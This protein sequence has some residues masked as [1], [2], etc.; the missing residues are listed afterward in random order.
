MNISKQQMQTIISNAPKGVDTDKIQAMYISKGYNIEGVDTRQAQ[1]YISTKYPELMKTE[2]LVAPQ[3]SLRDKVQE[4]TGDVTWVIDDIR[5]SSTK[6]S[7]NIDAAQ[8]RFNTGE[9]GLASTV[10]QT[11]GQ[12]AGAGADAI[13]AAFKGATN[14]AFSDKT[15]KDITDVIGKFGAKVMANPQV[16]G[17]IN[18]YNELTPEQQANVDAVGGIVSLVGEFIGGGVGSKAAKATTKG[19]KQA[20][21]EIVGAVGDA[22][23]Q[24]FQAG[25]KILPKSEN[26]MNK[27]ARLT[28]TQAR[29]FEQLTG[30]THGQ[31]LTETGNFGTPDEIIT[32]ESEKF[33]QSLKSVDDTLSQLDGN[34]NDGIIDDVLNELQEKAVATST[35]NVKS[36]YLD[37]VNEL[38][39]KNT[40]SGLSM[41]EINELK[42]LYERNVKLGYNKM[43]DAEKI[44]RATNLD[45]A[46]REWQIAKAE[47]LGFENLRDLNKQT[48]ASKQLINSL[49]DQVIGKTGLND[50]TLTDWIMLS[51]GDPTAVAGLLTKK[52]FSS[53]KVQAKIAQWLN[54]AEVS[55]II[56]PKVKGSYIDQANTATTTINTTKNNIPTT[57]PE[58]TTPVKRPTKNMLSGSSPGFVRIGGEMKDV[59]RFVDKTNPYSKAASFLDETDRAPIEEFRNAVKNKTP[60]S[61]KLTDDVD[62]I[63]EAINRNVGKQLINPYGTDMS[64]MKQLS[65]LKDADDALT[66]KAIEQY[67]KAQAKLGNKKK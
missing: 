66:Q 54:D 37:R 39:A 15:E 60:I 17:I 23:T 27:V 32:R 64:K 34:F 4:A 22:T 65:L 62:N 67:D 30:K 16:Q 53:K 45:N 13:G 36:P 46:L 12:L 10:L 3:P 25:K 28:P 41:S 35:K 20:S 43:I 5:D 48:Q 31:Y 18:K 49:G 38:M 33:A 9:Q 52:F 29:K 8:Q 63:I 6:R 1:Q 44:Q 50:V 56:K 57:V 59:T 24:T 47:E 61:R 55:P 42:R 21:T 58:P 14:L 11:G 7:A 19:F 2:T 51:G 26:I 40:E